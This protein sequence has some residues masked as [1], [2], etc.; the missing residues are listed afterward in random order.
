MARSISSL[1]AET[2]KDSGNSI[3]KDAA[4]VTAARC[5]CGGGRTESDKDMEGDY[6]ATRDAKVCPVILAPSPRQ[7][8]A[9]RKPNNLADAAWTLVSD[10][11]VFGLDFVISI[12]IRCAAAAVFAQFVWHP[13]WYFWFQRWMVTGTLERLVAQAFQWVVSHLQAHR[14]A[15]FG[16]WRR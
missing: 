15:P 9:S 7:A 14:V 3:F 5:G 11:A 13:T 10:S 8:I 1:R 6:P 12:S 4:G 2:G 16:P